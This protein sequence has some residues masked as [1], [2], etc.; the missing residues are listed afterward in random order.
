MLPDGTLCVDIDEDARIVESLQTCL[1]ALLGE[2]AMKNIIISGSAAQGLKC[3]RPTKRGDADI[4]VISKFPVITRENQAIAFEPESEPGFFKIKTLPEWD[5][6]PTVKCDQVAYVSA[7]SL[8]NLRSIWWNNELELPIIVVSSQHDMMHF[9]EKMERAS[10]EGV[11]FTIT[12]GRST[13][14]EK[15]DYT[16]RS[17]EI[18]WQSYKEHILPFVDVQLSEKI[19]TLGNVADAL[20]KTSVHYSASR[21][22]LAT[23]RAKEAADALKSKGC[24]NEVVACWKTKNLRSESQVINN[25]HISC[26]RQICWYF[27]MSLRSSNLDEL[28]SEA[29][30]DDEDEG[31]RGSYDFVPAIQCEG[32]PLLEESWPARVAEKEWPKPSIVQDVLHAGFQLVPRTSKSEGSDPGSS[33]RLSFNEA[34]TILA[35]SLNQVQ[36]ECFRC[37][38]MYYYEKLETDP[39]LLETYHLKTILFWTLENTSESFWRKDD[40]AYCCITLLSNLSESLKS[41]CLFHYFIP[42]NNIFQHLDKTALKKAAQKVDLIINDPIGTTGNIMKGILQYYA[43]QYK[44]ADDGSPVEN[45]L[46]REISELS[47]RTLK[48]STKRFFEEVEILQNY[49]DREDVLSNISHIE[50]LD[51]TEMKNI[52]GNQHLRQVLHFCFDILFYHRIRG[53]NI[54]WVGQ[55]MAY[56]FLSLPVAD[57]ILLDV[58]G[59]F[60]PDEAKTEMFKVK[61]LITIGATISS[62]ADLFKNAMQNNEGRDTRGMLSKDVVSDFELD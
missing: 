16:V 20:I 51:F 27:A 15:D 53:G 28:R 24:I 14:D 44:E 11:A 2:A 23:K 8:R 29:W 36:R 1:T 55:D 57:K 19:V 39:K 7:D 31:V 10:D 52:L 30:H 3:E 50:H 40:M 38:K 60:L 47:T 25:E 35:K 42:N 21:Y 12:W 4:V 13:L 6:Y 59:N 56:I 9:Y 18:L 46:S 61:E 34:E 49:K 43:E 54:F 22:A 48:K 17:F 62:L 58:M 45:K 37:L 32:F 33:F 5:Q 26:L 41:G